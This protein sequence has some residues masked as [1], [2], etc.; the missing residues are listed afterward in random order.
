M[1]NSI[2]ISKMRILGHNR[3]FFRL[4]MMMLRN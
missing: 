4:P 3:Y 2:M 1:P